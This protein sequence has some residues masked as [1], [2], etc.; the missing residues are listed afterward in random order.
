M[1]TPSRGLS[2]LESAALIIAIGGLG[3]QESLAELEKAEP[4][5]SKSTYYKR[6]R[7]AN[8]SLEKKGLLLRVVDKEDL[9]DWRP[10]QQAFSSLGAG[11][12]TRAFLGLS[13]RLLQAER[14]AGAA[15]IGA[16]SRE[17]EL[18]SMRVKVAALERELA[19]L[20][21][22]GNSSLEARLS[23]R[24]PKLGLSSTFMEVLFLLALVELMARNR[25]ASCSPEYSGIAETREF[26]KLMDTLNTA[27]QKTEG[28]RLNTRPAK[29]L[30][31][32]RN[33]I[34]HNGLVTDPVHAKEL[35]GIGSFVDY[36]YQQLFENPGTATR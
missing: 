27:L 3:G 22:Q 19:Q 26:N 11:E 8:E 25:L 23:Q 5:F 32:F 29:T 17:R 1:V 31:D 15:E 24:F 12:L 16:D 9:E 21:Q 4:G 6:R 13:T 35:E 14:R 30:H 7:E 28:R 2:K 33:E 34:I 18:V 36:L 20:K 10:T